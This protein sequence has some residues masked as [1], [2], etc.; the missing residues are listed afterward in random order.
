MGIPYGLPWVD[1]SPAIGA[2]GTILFR[3]NGTHN[4]YALNPGWLEEMGFFPT[5]NVIVF[6]ASHRGGNGNNL[7]LARQER[8]FLP[9]EAGRKAFFLVFHHRSPGQII[10]HPRQGADGTVCFFLPRWMEISTRCGRTVRSA[11]GFH[12]GGVT[13]SSPVLD[14]EGGRTFT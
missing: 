2:D 9:A 7:F 11:G 4:F 14:P 5:G 3:F 10:S 12:T 1:S 6:L 8:K 13:E